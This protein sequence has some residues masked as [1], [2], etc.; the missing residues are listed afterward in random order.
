MSVGISCLAHQCVLG[1]PCDHVC[2]LACYYYTVLKY[3]TVLLVVQPNGHI[4]K[5]SHTT[6]KSSL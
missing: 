4:N 5:F 3:K 6:A 2:S 1:A